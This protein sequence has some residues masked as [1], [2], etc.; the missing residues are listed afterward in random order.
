MEMT[1]EM[2]RKIAEAFS[3][4]DHEMLKELGVTFVDEL[5]EEKHDIEI[6]KFLKGMDRGGRFW[7]L[8]DLK[9]NSKLI[10]EVEKSAN[11]PIEN[12]DMG[13]ETDR[14]EEGEQAYFDPDDEDATGFKAFNGS[15]LD[16]SA[17][18][19][20]K[21]MHSN[22]EKEI[23]NLKDRFR[24]IP[25]EDWEKNYVVNINNLQAV[26]KKEILKRASEEAMLPGS[27]EVI[28]LRKNINV[29]IESAQKL[30]DEWAHEKIRLERKREK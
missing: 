5:A 25:E 24:I 29:L 26:L 20:A 12:R 27:E 13:D 19:R 6:K 10:A 1:E 2:R 8:S 9:R 15:K 11:A 17:L 30:F 4:N 21:K 18:E 23:E 3:R 22:A 14:A 28:R 16:P 7:R